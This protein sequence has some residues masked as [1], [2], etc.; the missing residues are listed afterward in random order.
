MA[1]ES[2]ISFFDSLIKIGQRFQE[3]FGIFGNAIGD[4]LGF[5]AVKSGDK[6]SKVGEHFK[7]I[8]D[9]L[10]TT[11]NKLKE[12]SIKISEAKNADGSTI[13]AVKGAIKGAND[14]FERLIA[15]L[16]TLADTA[17]EAGNTDIG[18]SG[19]AAAGAADENSV[20]AVI[21]NVKKIIEAAN[22]S[23][24]NIEKGNAG[25]PVSADANTDALAVLAANAAAGA[26][27]TAKLAAEVS[28]AD[29]WAM[30]D[31]IN[32]AKTAVGVQLDA[33]TN[34][35]AGELATGTPNQANGSKAATNADLAA[36]VALKVM[37][38][39]GKFSNAAN[40]ADAVKAAAVSAVN[41][42]LGVLDFIIRKTV[43]NNLDKIRETVKGIKYSETTTES[44]EASSTQP[45]TAK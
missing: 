27:A 14:V 3:I 18:D 6:R 26:G 19:A 5:T 8:G 2:R 24:V 21:D 11:K 40:E 44:A 15:A 10:T 23:S 34:Y 37:T 42:V 33:N 32:S 28:K 16:T 41:K 29:P 25:V 43:S 9:G 35:G 36:A 20:K 22:K 38:K 45:A 39:G 12:L 30:I 7:T 13:E 31:K 4:T 17:K 1:A